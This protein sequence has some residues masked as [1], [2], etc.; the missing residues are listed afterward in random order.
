MSIYGALYAG[1]T[2]LSAN[3]TALGIISDNIANVNTVGYKRTFSDFSTLVTGTGTVSDFSPGGVRAAG[4]L[5]VEDQGLLLGSSSPTDLAISGDGFFVTSLEPTNNGATDRILFTR[6]GSFTQDADGFLRNSAGHYLQ[7]WPV[8]ANGTVNANPSDLSQLEPVN[9][10]QIGGTAEAT[11]QLSYNANLLASQPVSAAEATYAPGTSA[12]N[13]AS[14]NVTADFQRSVQIFDSQGGF[15]TLTIS[16]LKS[17]TPN[18][19]HAEM[20]IEPASEVQTGAPLVNGQVAT[21]TLAFGTDGQF[22]AASTTLPTSLSFLASA[23]TPGGGQFGW[24]TSL[25]IGAQTVT[26]DLGSANSQ[27][28]FTQFDSPST[29]ISTSVNGAVFGN[30][31]GVN[32]AE[33][34]FVTALFD[35]GI[36]RQIYQ[37][38][39]STFVNPNGLNRETGNAYSLTNESGNFN[40]KVPGQ[41]GAGLISSGSLES[42]TVDVAEEFTGLITTQRAYSAN[43]RIITTADDMLEELIRIR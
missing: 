36:Q 18:Q 12:N 17:S 21:G 37:V 39:V 41:A 7:G 25:G 15:R 13:M 1:V 31:T 14:G 35:N 24:A 33:D 38:P 10:S 8:A 26:L 43:T 22:D 34:G 28:G 30:F 32:V 4:K 2:G 3:S 11:T 5:L 9:V 42:S 29:L 20:H 19:W 40:L 16:L 6:A 27:G 23:A